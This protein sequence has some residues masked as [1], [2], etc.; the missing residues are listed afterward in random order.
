MNSNKCRSNLALS[1]KSPA[2][3]LSVPTAP[4]RDT[5][6][7][8]RSA[9][10]PEMRREE[11]SVMMTQEKLEVY[12]CCDYLAAPD[13]DDHEFCDYSDDDDEDEIDAMDA[14]SSLNAACRTSICEWMY[15]VVD[16]FGVDREGEST[17]VTTCDWI[18][19]RFCSLIDLSRLSAQSSPWPCP[20]RID[21]S[22]SVTAPHDKRSISYP[23]RPCISPLKFIRPGGG[24]KLARYCPY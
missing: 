15:R 4:S 10:C 12:Q 9:S 14:G 19:D 22:L 20:T 8:I 17:V 21:S 23:P 16:H 5:I 6:G 3:S 2:P 11:L 13:D 1:T 24:R 18:P 7:A